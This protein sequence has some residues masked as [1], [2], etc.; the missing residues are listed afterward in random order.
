M[1]CTKI[2]NLIINKNKEGLIKTY[3]KLVN[4]KRINPL[5]MNIQTYKRL[6]YL[7]ES[8]RI[9]MSINIDFDNEL[10]YWMWLASPLIKEYLLNEED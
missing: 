3:I 8:K 5:T 9:K 4:S 7:S 2:K 10:E 1:E 6:D